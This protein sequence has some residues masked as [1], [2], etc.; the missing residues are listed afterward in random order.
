MKFKIPNI[1]YIALKSKLLCKRILNSGKR[2]FVFC[3]AESST[4]IPEI[5]KSVF[6]GLSF[7]P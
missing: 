5:L 7:S 6:L 4:E 2:A 1:Y 3:F